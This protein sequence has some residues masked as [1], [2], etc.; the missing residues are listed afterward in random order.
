MA[1][2][3]CL[4]AQRTNPKTP[5]GR[6]TGTE[7]S[8]RIRTQT[9]ASPVASTEPSTA[10]RRALSRLVVLCACMLLLTACSAAGKP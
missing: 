6:A 1:L 8:I 9:T 2:H 7:S 5:C 3:T 4:P 10:Q